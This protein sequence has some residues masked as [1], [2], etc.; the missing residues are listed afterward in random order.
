MCI[1]WLTRAAAASSPLQPLPVRRVLGHFID[2]VAAVFAA[3]WVAEIGTPELYPTKERFSFPSDEFLLSAFLFGP[4]PI[5]LEIALEL[6]APHLLPL[7]DGILPYPTGYSGE[8]SSAAWLMFDD[9]A[10]WAGPEAGR[11]VADGV[12]ALAHEAPQTKQELVDTLMR[13]NGNYPMPGSVNS[14]R[15]LMAHVTLTEAEALGWVWAD[16]WSSWR[17]VS[18]VASAFSR[19]TRRGDSVLSEVLATQ[20]A[21]DPGVQL[22][23]M[24][25]FIPRF[26]L[27]VRRALQH[28]Y[29]E[30]WR[31]VALS[32]D[33]RQYLSGM[34][35]RDG[36]RARDDFMSYAEPALLV[37]LVDKRWGDAFKVF[38]ETFVPQ[39]GFP[40]IT[41]R[42]ALSFLNKSIDLRN[43][44][45]HSKW[46]LT[47]SEN[48]EVRQLYDTMDNWMLL[49]ERF[50]S[51]PPPQDPDAQ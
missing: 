42:A 45:M 23:L 21:E 17:L 4:G 1:G 20:R 14:L 46:K 19:A 41:K 25:D 40:R 5:Q 24:A 51:M 7:L 8:P 6:V 31:N 48:Q 2:F 44:I 15:Q 50:V 47:E 39:Q 43:A 36:Y 13:G 34:Q 32:P 28:A 37:G 27:F 30:S 35:G 38:F 18:D 22:R 29:G 16:R 11:W 9:L 33:E 3:K 12:A 10:S 49:L 26:R